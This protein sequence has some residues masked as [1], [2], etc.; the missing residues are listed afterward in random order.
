VFADNPGNAGNADNADNAGS[1]VFGS[2][3]CPVMLLAFQAR[4]VERRK[5]VWLT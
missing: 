4:T 5:F 2:G 3:D 1:A